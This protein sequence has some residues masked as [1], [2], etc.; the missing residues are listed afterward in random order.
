MNPSPELSLDSVRDFIIYRGGKV[1]NH[2]LVKQFKDV[3]TDPENRV[4]ARNLFKEIVNEVA[5]IV[6][7]DDGEKYLILKKRYRPQ[8][9]MDQYSNYSTPTMSPEPHYPYASPSGTPSRYS[10]QDSLTSS[11]SQSGLSGLRHPPPYRPPPPP[12]VT[13]PPHLSPHLILNKSPQNYSPSMQPPNPYMQPSHAHIP[14]QNIPYGMN[15]SSQYSV[16][17]QPQHPPFVHS[18]SFNGSA[19]MRAP[20][21]SNKSARSHSLDSPS[22][23]FDSRGFP[24][25]NRKSRPTTLEL[26]P[27][28]LDGAPPPPVPPRRRNSEK[29]LSLADKENMP[30]PNSASTPNEEDKTPVNSA[31]TTPGDN[32]EDP[33][34]NI[35]VKECMRKFNRLA[36]ESALLQATSPTNKPPSSSALGSKRVDKQSN[37]QDDDTASVTSVSPLDPTSKKWLI[38]AAQGDYQALAKMASENP[39]LVSLKH[40]FMGYT[41]L[42]W[43]A[44]H[45]NTDLVKL[46]AGTYQ[47]DV[48][49]RTNGGY[50][51]LHLAM[52]FGREEVYNILVQVY[53]ADPDIRD[54]SGRKPRQY[55]ISQDTSVSADTFRKIKARKKNSERDL[56]FLR[57]GS[58]NVRVKKTT[59]AFSNFLGGKSE[60]EKLHKTWGSADNLHQEDS[61]MAPPKF[62]SIKK[63]KS[64]RGPSD[65][66]SRSTPSTP[67]FKT[68]H[69]PRTPNS[70]PRPHSVGGGPDY[71]NSGDS[72]SDTACGFG[73]QWQG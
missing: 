35:S 39:R 1:K 34:H 44:K 15:P 38:R 5:T 69:H 16:Q 54:Y 42:H 18:N 12:L 67:D 66:V 29:S 7:S 45:G 37:H 17:N 31:P 70:S 73:T 8:H 49:V 63:R 47:A 61:R 52:Q 13:T 27:A 24:D 51:P 50:T 11:Y 19:A 68:L 14:P 46:I 40:P 58:L 36:S 28:M 2:E 25:G 64:K 9:L 21:F 26:P 57:I 33:E 65:F 56:G 41:A 3:L 53:G 72:D 71:R 23:Q 30:G 4:E 55:Q 43:A 60:P 6:R 59:E 48:N 20:S 62:T 22:S 32:P 10:S